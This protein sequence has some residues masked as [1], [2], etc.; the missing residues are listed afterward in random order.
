M[1]KKSLT[2]YIVAV[3]VVTIFDIVLIEYL[4]H[5]PAPAIM[6]IPISI[7][8]VFSY[9][10]SGQL[11]STEY[12]WRIVVYAVTSLF[13]NLMIFLPVILHSK[14]KTRIAFLIIQIG[15][16]GAYIL[17]IFLFTEYF[18]GGCPYEESRKAAMVKT[19]KKWGQNQINFYQF[20]DTTMTIDGHMSIRADG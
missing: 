15:T 17:S 19:P 7:P 16:L 3:L 5:G 14:I 18:A 13:I 2:P 11:L 10:L 6:I 8:T 4:Q 1:S 9:W 20:L 12:F